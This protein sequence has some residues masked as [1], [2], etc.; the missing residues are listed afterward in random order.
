MTK[1]LGVRNHEVEE[2]RIYE[3]GS[4]HLLQFLSVTETIE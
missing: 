2:F 4:I 3:N 1:D